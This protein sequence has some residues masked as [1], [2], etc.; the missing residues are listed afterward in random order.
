M[1]S[2]L[3]NTQNDN[4]KTSQIISS[5]WPK[6]PPVYTEQELLSGNKE[7]IQMKPILN[8]VKSEIGDNNMPIVTLTW[9]VINNTNDNNLLKNIKEYE[10]FSY[11]ES[12]NNNQ[13]QDIKEIQDWTIVIFI[14]K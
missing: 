12:I 9:N 8:Q 11:K 7:I 10:I 14:L 2:F 4:D 1:K 6:L 5:C 13:D 3:L